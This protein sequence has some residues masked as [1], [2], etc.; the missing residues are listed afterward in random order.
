MIKWVF[1]QTSH[2]M[3]DDILKRTQSHIQSNL[4]FDIHTT[5]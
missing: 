5:F 1:N 3:F 2:H 4:F